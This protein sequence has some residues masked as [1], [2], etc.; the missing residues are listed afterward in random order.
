MTVAGL[1]IAN[2]LAGSI[3]VEQVFSLPG[4][5]RLVL[6]A[7]GNRDWP[8]IQGLVLFIAALVVIINLVVDILYR[9]L[10]PRIIWS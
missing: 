10:D 8:L 6:F 9:Y 4:L 1:Q 7:V 2:L 3:I 5:G